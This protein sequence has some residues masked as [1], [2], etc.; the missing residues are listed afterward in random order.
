M[1]ELFTL[2]FA[3]FTLTSFTQCP[4]GDVEFNSQLD[5]DNFATN[6]PD[7]TEISGNLTIDN[8]SEENP[9]QNL[10]G[11]S[12]LETIEG[13]LTILKIDRI[14]GETNEIIPGSLEGLENIVTVNE[15]I[16]GVDALSAAYHIESLAPLSN[17][18][19]SV[20]RIEL[21]KTIFYEEMPD[22]SELEELGEFAWR[23]CNGV[24]ATPQFS[25]LTSL[26]RYIVVGNDLFLDS[27]KTIHIPNVDAIS[28]PSWSDSFYGVIIEECVSLESIVGGSGLS[29]IE[30]AILSGIDLV[31]NLSAFDE[32]VGVRQLRISGCTE[33]SFN[34]FLN[35]ESAD[36][37]EFY[38]NGTLFGCSEF[39]EDF[40]I[41][42]GENA[43]ALIAIEEGIIIEGNNIGNL[44]FT[45]EFDKLGGLSIETE[46][47]LEIE[48][49]SSLDSIVNTST[50]N[51]RLFIRGL[52]LNSFP[53]FSDLSRID[54]DLKLFILDEMSGVNN[55]Q[56]FNALEFIGKELNLYVNN[57]NTTFSSL[58]G[59]ESLVH[60]RDISISGAHA[61]EDVSALTNL[62]YLSDLKL[63]DVLSFDSD[64]SFEGIDNIAVLR[65]SQCGLE[66]FP[67]FPN[68][69][70]VGTIEILD[71]DNILATPS[72][73]NLQ[74]LGS[75]YVEGCDNMS[76]I[77]GYPSL[78]TLNS[79]DLIDNEI[80]EEIDL[81]LDL[82]YTGSWVEWTFNPLLT[83]CGN[84]P[85]I[86]NIISQTDPAL[87][88]IYINGDG[89]NIDD[90]VA[91]DCL[92]SAPH[93]VRCEHNAFIDQSGRLVIQSS[94]SVTASVRIYTS[95]GQLVLSFDEI[96]M[97]AQ[98]IIDL[99]DLSSGIYM[100]EI[101]SKN[102]RSTEKIFIL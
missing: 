99:P 87:N 78:Q 4:S 81:P 40:V 54:Y 8:Q 62:E 7:C 64:L 2:I 6:F 72:F 56:S 29:Y 32:V 25:N 44:S 24:G 34:S 15:L 36:Q 97:S 60:C 48:G 93:N 65:L 71:S 16:I 96:A 68:L 88:Y 82:T 101:A 59:L 89:C 66:S 14:D 95:K 21:S 91:Q 75:L 86:C 57:L 77:S 98:T 47:I 30:S 45:A 61:L 74:S 67:N 42:V 51:G 26:D 43:E 85:V 50:S 49:F 38:P 92:L 19:S 76:F 55:M 18:S 10:T 63:I 13:S 3:L 94:E 39:I 31:N 5:V 52:G 22:F 79:F 80:L 9:I 83:D 12:S 27:L 58:D 20:E 102:S 23:N 100:T 28:G 70:N 41:R 69:E 84:S 35:L 37:I 33:G 90:N 53:D 11:L 17:I 73:P 46:N 1:K